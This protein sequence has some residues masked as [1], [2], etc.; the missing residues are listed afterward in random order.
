M[1]IRF[2]RDEVYETEG[3]NMGRT[4]AAGDV[5][6]ARKDFAERWLRRGAAEVVGKGDPKDGE[7]FVEVKAAKGSDASGKAPEKTSGGETADASGETPKADA[8][9]KAQTDLLGDGAGTDKAP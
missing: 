6:D 1:R 9:T 7:L 2:V 8:G 4:F 5:I 3:R